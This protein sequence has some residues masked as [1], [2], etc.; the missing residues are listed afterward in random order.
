MYRWHSALSVQDTRW[1]EEKFGELFAKSG[2]GSGG[3][4]GGTGTGKGFGEIT[5]DD[6]VKAV[7]ALRPPGDV[8]TW[9]LDGLVFTFIFMILIL[10]LSDFGYFSFLRGAKHKKQT[11]RQAA[12]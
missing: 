5:V 2:S 11:R 10:I 1:T 8:R 3:E 4:S 9:V 12:H 7:G 6:F